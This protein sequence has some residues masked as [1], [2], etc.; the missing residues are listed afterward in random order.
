MRRTIVL[1]ATMALTL[2]VASGVGWAINKIGTDGPDTLMGT[3]RAD[4]LLG[5]A[6][7]DDIF[8]LKGRDN[9]LGG[10]GNDWLI[11][12]SPQDRSMAGDKNLAG[13]SGNDGV[14]AGQGSDNALGGGGN[15]LLVDGDLLESAH[16]NFY[17]GSG[18]DAIVV[19]HK[20]AFRDMVV[21]G[22]GFDY[23]LADPKDVVSSDCESVRI[24]RVQRFSVEELDEQEQEFFASPP[25]V[26]LEAGLTAPPI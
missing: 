7:N 6:G 2:L 26:A 23:V 24:L 10:E 4:N 15:D 5:R 12:G 14:F 25:I 9:L 18:T 19:W 11:A 3:N 21:C 20:P 1:L 8:G 13:G 22:D 17:G 16:D